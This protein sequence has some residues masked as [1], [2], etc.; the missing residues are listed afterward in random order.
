MNPLEDVIVAV[1]VKKPELKGVDGNGFGLPNSRRLMD[2][3]QPQYAMTGFTQIDP[4]TGLPATIFN[5]YADL[6]WEYVWHCHLLGH[7]E[8]DMMRPLVFRPASTTSVPGTN[9][10]L[11]LLQ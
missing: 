4:K 2:P 9:L 7:E 8:N 11:L 5:D 1:R 6:K 3:T 10:L